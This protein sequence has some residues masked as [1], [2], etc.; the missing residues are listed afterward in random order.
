M[1][2]PAAAVDERTPRRLV[3][4]SEGA[5]AEVSAATYQAITEALQAHGYPLVARA[6]AQL[7]AGLGPRATLTMLTEARGV[8]ARVATYREAYA[9]AVQGVTLVAG[10]DQLL[11]GLAAEGVVSA[12]ATNEHLIG[13]EP[14]LGRLGLGRH[15]A[16]VITGDDVG[17]TGRKPAGAMARWARR[18]MAVDPADV[19][20][21]GDT[22]P[23]VEMGRA[24]EVATVAVTWGP[25][26]RTELAQAGPTWIVDDVD[27]LARL[28]GAWLDHQARP[29]ERAR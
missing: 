14:L 11:E 1:W 28:L 26:A 7:L 22:V 24:A 25:H 15:L 4:W 16:L 13:V 12:L 8:D 19:I 5:L 18:A 6:Y 20:V 23:D 3:V 29:G 9:L 21:V 27:E 17:P 10:V 2:A